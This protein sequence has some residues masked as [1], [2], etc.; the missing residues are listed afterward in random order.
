M[1]PES[2]APSGFYH[3]YAV[4]EGLPRRWRPPATGVGGGPVVAR[5]AAELTLIVTP[6]AAPIGRTPAALAAH[7]DVVVG[8]LECRAVVPLRFGT[9]LAAAQLDRWLALHLARVRAALA[10]VRGSVEM[11]VRLLRL[12]AGGAAG[13]S[14]GALADQLIERAGCASW[15]YVPAGRAPN[16]S[17]SLAFLVR[18]DDVQSFLARIAPVASRAEG[19][20]VV[21]S[22]PW[23]PYSFAPALDPTLPT[24][25]AG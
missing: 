15:R 4:V 8:L 22:G 21:P 16:A 17:A 18:R 2:P 12:D 5:A 10:E 6:L 1:V 3:L 24:A 9:T 11:S 14:L 25:L 23:P 19:V 7:D 20:A 13:V